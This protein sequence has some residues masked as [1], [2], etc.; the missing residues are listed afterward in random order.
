ME[1]SRGLGKAE[2]IRDGNEAFQLAHTDSVH[3][4][5]VFYSCNHSNFGSEYLW[6]CPARKSNNAYFRTRLWTAA[7]E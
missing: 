7:E 1:L 3:A 4:N 5:S 6:D 2:V